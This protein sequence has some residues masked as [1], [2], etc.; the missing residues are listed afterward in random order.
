MGTATIDGVWYFALII[1][2]GTVPGGVVALQIGFNF[3]NVPL[4][5]SARA[6]GTVML[7]RLSRDA[8]RGDLKRFRETYESGVSW[9]WFVAAPTSVIF[10]VLAKPLSHALA[11]GQMSRGDGPALLAAAIA[12]MGLALIP[13]A[14][15]EF[16]RYACY[17][18]GDVHAPLR[19]G[20]ALIIIT[21]IGIPVALTAFDGPAML[22]ALGVL[23]A[24]GQLARCMVVDRAARRDTSAGNAFWWRALVRHVGIALVSIGVA[25]VVA[26]FVVIGG[27]GHVQAL[28][29]VVLATS[30]G[31]ACYTALQSALRAPELPMILRRRGSRTRPLPVAAEGSGS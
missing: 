22:G 2:A 26:H 11:F 31:L 23:V 10:V 1:A 9:A 25:A 28:A 29:E 5:L 7:P 18:C 3:Y 24:V 12:S 17:A 19:A 16:A 30:V 13:A 14:T 20:I 27:S 15:Q 4:A 21:A 6:V 8:I